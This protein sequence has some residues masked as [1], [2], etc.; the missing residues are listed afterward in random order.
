[1]VSFHKLFFLLKIVQ[2]NLSKTIIEATVQSTC[3][4][5]SLNICSEKEISNHGRFSHSMSFYL[6]ES[7]LGRRKSLGKTKNNGQEE[8]FEFDT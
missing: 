2:N 5:S 4:A 3:L 1:M 6:V 7:V 8:I